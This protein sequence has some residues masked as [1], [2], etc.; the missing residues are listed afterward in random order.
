MQGNIGCCFEQGVLISLAA[1][2]VLRA[3]GRNANSCLLIAWGGPGLFA[4][5]GG[6][7][8]GGARG[9]VRWLAIGVVRVLAGRAATQLLEV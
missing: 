6:V 7:Q 4:L 5:V 9:V 8:R 3:K 2:R 1:F